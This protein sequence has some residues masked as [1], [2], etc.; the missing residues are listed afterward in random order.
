MT[1]NIRHATFA[2]ET[3]L[4]DCIA[5]AYAPFQELRLPPVAEDIID[6]IR[7]HN[8]WVAEVAG[9]VCGGIVLVLGDYAH[10][11]N[12]AVRPDAG[13][14]GIGKALIN[15]ATDAAAAAGYN[16]VRLATHQEMTS[17]QA[18]YRKLGWIEAGHEGNKVYFTKKLL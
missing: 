15:Q 16:E 11:A 1:I 2:D 10:I 18:F 8:V 13:G 9:D 14:L 5:V 6:D 4:T 7:D 17:T 12:L 3:A